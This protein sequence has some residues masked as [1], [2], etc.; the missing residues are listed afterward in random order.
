[1]PTNSS[2]EFSTYVARFCRLIG[3]LQAG[4]YGRHRGRLI[5]R[6]HEDQFDDRMGHYQEL[7]RR[8]QATIETGDTIDELLIVELRAAETEL[9][10]ETS[11]FLPNT[12]R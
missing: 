12:G 6:L 11:W 7:G 2:Y 3:E 1:M 4:Q 9:V 5:L 10:I 8:L